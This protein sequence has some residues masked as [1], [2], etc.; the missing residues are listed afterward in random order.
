MSL[1]R[2]GQASS[3]ACLLCRQASGLALKSLAIGA[4]VIVSAC[5]RNPS[6]MD[7][8]QWRVAGPAYHVPRDHVAPRNVQGPVVEDDGIEEQAAP[9]VRNRRQIPDDPSEPFSP[10]YGAEPVRQG[11]NGHEPAVKTSAWEPR[12]VRTDS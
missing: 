8:D 9:I 4:V 10:N 1:V 2:F 11:L 6:P 7:S 3:E 12:V 5:A